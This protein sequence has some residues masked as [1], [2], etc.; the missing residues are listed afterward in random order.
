MPDAR[1]A[2]TDKEHAVPEAL[3]ALISMLP[4]TAYLFV[5]SRFPSRSALPI[6]VYRLS[7]YGMVTRGCLKKTSSIEFM[8]QTRS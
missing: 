7:L 5:P 4:S 8:L 1:D 6:R 3:T 2:T